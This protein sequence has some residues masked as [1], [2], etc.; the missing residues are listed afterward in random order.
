MRRWLIGAIG[1]A[2]LA[3]VLVLVFE[4]WRWQLIAPLMLAVLAA[5]VAAWRLWREPKD[6]SRWRSILA[7][8]AATSVLVVAFLPP[9]LFPLFDIPAPQGEQ[10]VGTQTLSLLDPDRPD[11]TAEGAFGNRELSLQVWYPTDATDKERAPLMDPA[12][13]DGMVSGTMPTFIF[14]HLS[15]IETQ[16]QTNAPFLDGIEQAPV[17]L[18]VPGFRSFTTQSTV[19]AQDLASRGYVVISIGSPGDASALAYPD[20]RVVGFANDSLLADE[21]GV[22][23]LTRA[24]TATDA[25]AQ[26][27]AIAEALREMRGAD[28]TLR[29]QVADV[30]LVV[31]ALEQ[32]GIPGLEI[33]FDLSRLS[34]VGMSLGGAVAAQACAE[35]DPCGKAINLDGFQFGDFFGVHY[36]K[37]LL[38]LMSDRGNVPALNG[39]MYREAGRPFPTN[40]IYREVEGA[41][42]MDFTDFALASPVLK[43]LA[44][45][46]LLGA[47][48]GENMLAATSDMVATFLA[49]STPDGANIGRQA[50]THRVVLR[51]VDDRVEIPSRSLNHH[52]P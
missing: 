20:G 15:L 11:P 26:R 49:S 42:H 28:A 46:P 5:I 41:S 21:R 18:F 8:A 31:E 44:P 40:V 19:L 39:T 22:E 27:S 7:G 38:V 16:S 43:T 1:L 35:I 51:S 24:T 33:D 13:A 6:R 12:V 2:A 4:P 10:A 32:R 14:G 52:Q 30:E 37:P 23:A 50:A 47:V 29:G 9:L 48:D 17:V 3:I 34:I 36:S 45:N 25:A